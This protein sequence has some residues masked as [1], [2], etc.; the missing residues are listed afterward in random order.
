[1]LLGER[2]K[3]LRVEANLT[4]KELGDKVHVTKVSICLYEQGVR[5]PGLEILTDLANV[6]NVSLDYLVGRVDYR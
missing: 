6:F 3:E 5:I 1:M 2:I 4:Q